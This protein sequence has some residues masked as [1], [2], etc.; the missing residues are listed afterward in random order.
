MSALEVEATGRVQAPAGRNKV[1][2]VAGGFHAA[3]DDPLTHAYWLATLPVAYWIRPVLPG[4]LLL[5]IDGR[6]GGFQTLRRLE[7][8]LGPLGR[9]Y[10]LQSSSGYGA[11]L[12]AAVDPAIELRQTA[13]F[14]GTGIDTRAAR[15][16]YGFWPGGPRGRR[17]RLALDLPMAPLP[18]AWVER[19][20]AVVMAPRQAQKV[21]WPRN[22][23]G[24]VRVVREAAT[25][26]RNH[27]LFWAAC[28]ACEQRLDL[29]RELGD[30]ARSVG[31]DD[32]EITATLRSAA[33]KVGAAA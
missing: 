25:G 19:L 8:D 14:L 24:L 33:R 11:H 10:T 32:R 12:W 4:E 13:G 22:S 23:N 15:R 30:A 2:L 1:P 26:N 7:R 9:T 18:D 6:H 3:S 20:T 29:D 28:R 31:L 16:G 17:Y 21:T 27:K 5:D